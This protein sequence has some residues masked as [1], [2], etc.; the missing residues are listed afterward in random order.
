VGRK[1]A[2]NAIKLG[3]GGYRDL[4]VEHY[5]R[6]KNGEKITLDEM[7]QARLTRKDAEFHNVS[8]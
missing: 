6:T 2:E 1:D 8:E 4:L 3:E 5:Q 7:I